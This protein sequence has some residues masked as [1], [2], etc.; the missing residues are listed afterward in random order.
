MGSIEISSRY[1][2]LL[3]GYGVLV[4]IIILL[5]I[6]V[7]INFFYYIFFKRFHKRII[8]RGGVWQEAFLYAINT[9]FRIFIW[10]LASVLILE[11]LSSVVQ[12]EVLYKFIALVEHVGVVVLLFWAVLNFVSRIETNLLGESGRKRYKA[13]ETL[14]KMVI[15]ILRVALIGF[16]LVILLQGVG[17]PVS[18]IIAFGGFGGIAVGFAAKDLLANFFGGLVIFFD[19]PFNLGDRIEIPEQ[20]IQGIV[21]HIGW[22]VTRVRLFDTRP[23][24]IPNATFST[25]I[26]ENITKRPNRQIKTHIQL[27][28]QDARAIPKILEEFQ[29]LLQAHD[30]IDQNRMRTVR[31]DEF[32]ESG[33]NILIYCFTLTPDWDRYLQIQQEIFLEFVKIVHAHGADFAF[34]TRSIYMEKV[35]QPV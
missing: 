22:R 1:R 26:I 35:Q 5:S 6:A 11:I 8:D 7:G 9:P 27:R 21:E 31:F 17:V 16:A 3:A 24:Y 4:G 13:D 2:E 18:G 12:E 34:P 25:T 20:K 28:Y 32:G 30:G 15:K 23:A 14:V 10:F 29:S 19:R 33:L